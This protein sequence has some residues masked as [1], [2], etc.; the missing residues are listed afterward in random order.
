M[1]K[2]GC[3]AVIDKFEEYL[4][5]ISQPT[6]DRALTASSYKNV[7]HS[8]TDK[9]INRELATYGDALL[10]LALCKILFN[11]KVENITVK[12]QDYE[13]DE[14]LVKVVASYYDLLKKIKFDEKDEEIPRNYEY[15]DEKHKYIATAVEALLAAYY[16]DNSEDFSLVIETAR[17]WKSLIDGS[18][19][20][21]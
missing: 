11:E 15:K 7:D 8:L 14:V 6:R 19:T 2:K 4:R 3:F 9:D 10:K 1:S 5:D 21:K 12:K 13:S 17:E 20:P 18:N 16:L